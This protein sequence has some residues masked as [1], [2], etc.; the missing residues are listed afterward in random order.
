MVCRCGCLAIL[1]DMPVFS[2]AYLTL[3]LFLFG[4]GVAGVILNRRN[5]I[6]LLL[7]VELMLMAVN[8][9][10][11]AC[12]AF[13]DDVVGQV[14]ALFVLTVAAAESSV[15]LAMLVVFYRLRATVNM[16]VSAQLQG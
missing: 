10:L 4:L 13:L 14:F 6:V 1:L 8:L 16:D 12:S 9:Q 11:V 2:V 3:S 7:S 5:V 15:G